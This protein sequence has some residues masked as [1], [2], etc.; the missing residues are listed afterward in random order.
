MV[1]FDPEGGEPAS[2]AGPH[3]RQPFCLM[4]AQVQE[5][6]RKLLS[7]RGIILETI[8]ILFKEFDVPWLFHFRQRVYSAATEDELRL[9]ADMLKLIGTVFENR[10]LL[11][12]GS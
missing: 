5:C 1:K 12:D 9:A 10:D 6:Q 7:M 2:A 4:D 8:N 11:G 3:D